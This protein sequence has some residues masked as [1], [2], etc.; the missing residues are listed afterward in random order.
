MMILHGALP[1][2]MA[3]A[4]NS[5]MTDQKSQIKHQSFKN[6]IRRVQLSGTSLFYLE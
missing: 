2:M 3:W 5:R 1:P 4:M 6:R